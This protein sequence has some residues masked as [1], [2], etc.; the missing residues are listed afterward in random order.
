[1]TQV[2]A[3]G[4]IHYW[5]WDEKYGRQDRAFTTTSPVIIKPGDKVKVVH[6]RLLHHDL[7]VLL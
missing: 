5:Y 3:D 4:T 7:S 6:M 1:V 2:D